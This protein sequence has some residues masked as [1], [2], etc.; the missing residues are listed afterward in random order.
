MN[1][2][3][4]NVSLVN[5]EENKRNVEIPRI[6]YSS[7]RIPLLYSILHRILPV[8][9]Y[10]KK[11]KSYYWWLLYFFVR[12]NIKQYSMCL[13]KFKHIL[14][15]WSKLS[16]HIL[17]NTVKRIVFHVYNILFGETSFCKDNKIVK[18]IILYTK[19]YIYLCLKQKRIPTLCELIHILKFKY[20]IEKYVSI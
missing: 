18:F 11:D 13:Y 14:P 12:K 8:N 9:Y 2:I 1:S 3:C 7:D 17:R 10:L 16:M 20:Q 5:L 19:Q 6:S 4:F 15:L